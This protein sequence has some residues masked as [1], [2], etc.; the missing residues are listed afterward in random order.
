[1]RQ[2]LR[3]FLGG[4]ILIA[5]AVIGA[6]TGAAQFG[7]EGRYRPEAVAAIIDRVHDDLSRGYTVWGLRKGDRERLTHAER[8]LRD[9]A[10]HWEH[11]KFD[12]GNLDGAVAAIQHVIDDN[13]LSGRERDALWNDIEELRRM[14]AGYERHEIGNR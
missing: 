11:G 1:M 5:L 4:A 10:G 3:G 2:T 8:Q 14:R 13:H 6:V 12:R 9:F 7:P